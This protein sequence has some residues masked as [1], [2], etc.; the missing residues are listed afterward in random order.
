MAWFVFEDTDGIWKIR[1]VSD[2][3]LDNDSVF[4]EKMNAQITCDALNA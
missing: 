2:D 4:K 3:T 1:E